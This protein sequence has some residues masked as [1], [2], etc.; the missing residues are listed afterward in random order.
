VHVYR[1]R[2]GAHF[3][4]YPGAILGESAGGGGVGHTLAFS[5]YGR[6]LLIGTS[7]SADRPGRVLVYKTDRTGGCAARKPT[8]IV[9]RSL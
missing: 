8:F 1:Q 9:L 7:P 5:R 3:E 4:R 6:Y 2:E